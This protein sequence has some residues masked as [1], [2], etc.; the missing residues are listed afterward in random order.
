MVPAGGA[1]ACSSLS[2]RPSVT[3]PGEGAGASSGCS[4]AAAATG[5]LTED[6]G[7]AV[8]NERARAAAIRSTTRPAASTRTAIP[9]RSGASWP[10]GST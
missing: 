3:V 6:A 10:D 8:G 9:W 1:T 4:C 5:W 7:A 2:V